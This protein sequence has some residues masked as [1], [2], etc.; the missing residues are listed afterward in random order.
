MKFIAR[1]LFNAALAP[2][3]Y[4]IGTAIIVRDLARFKRTP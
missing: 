1:M 4:L 3:L 2:L